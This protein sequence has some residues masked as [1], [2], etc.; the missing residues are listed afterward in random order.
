MCDSYG[1]PLHPPH[2]RRPYVWDSPSQSAHVWQALRRQICEKHGSSNLLTTTW[3]KA[4]SIK[5]VEN[6]AAGLKE[7][8]WNV[9]IHH[10]ATVERFY[11]NGSGPPSPW[12]IVDRMIHRHQLGQALLLQ[13]EMVNVGKRLNE[14]KAGKTLFRDLEGLLTK[15]NKTIK[16]VVVTTFCKYLSF[17]TPSISL[18][19]ENSLK[20][21]QRM[22]SQNFG[23]SW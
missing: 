3:D 18:F 2:Y 9:M 5:E 16:L 8:Y 21:S 6:R 11:V 14:T 10:G 22:D 15:Q 17:K 13:G 12:L 4:R 19:F 7:H 20:I 1:N 23:E